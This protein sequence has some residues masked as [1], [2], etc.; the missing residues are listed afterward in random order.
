M[1]PR[2]LAEKAGVST[3]T[4][5]DIENGKNKDIYIATLCKVAS[6]LG[7]SVRVEF[8]KGDVYEPDN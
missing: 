5:H 4:V 1:T 2:E 6:A 7:L 8:L 3:Q